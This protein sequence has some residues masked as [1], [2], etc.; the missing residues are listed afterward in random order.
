MPEV[1]QTNA[2]PNSTQKPNSNP[3]NATYARF[4]GVPIGL[5]RI[6]ISGLAAFGIVVAI[7]IFHPNL[8]D[9]VKFASDAA[10]ITMSPSK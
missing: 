4:K 9:R 10:L 3:F 1:N 7:S 2:N 6:V 8:A 5:R